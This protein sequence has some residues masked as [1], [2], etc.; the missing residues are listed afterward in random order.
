MGNVFH[1]KQFDV[2]HDRSA[3]KIGTDGVLLGAWTD[4]G[5][6]ATIWDA[7]CG[8]GL[9]ALMIAQRSTAKIYG[10]EIEEDAALEAQDNAL[11]SPWT[12]RIKVIHGDINLVAPDLPTP[13]LIICNP[14]FFKN[15]LKN[16]DAARSAARHESTLGA[17]SIIEI[18]AKFLSDIGCLSLIL[19]FDCY[20]EVEWNSA[21]FKLNIA[22][23]LD[24]RMSPS[25]TPSRTLWELSRRSV[26]GFRH[27]TADIRNIDGSYSDWYQ[28]LTLEYYTHLK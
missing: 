6:A 11:A 16:P 25:K 17:K 14:P 23:R 24:I 27:D 15:A 10:V 22:R 28:Q 19:P 7:G 5:E 13:D 12:N 9:L 2:V 1:F 20:E 4:P 26:F 21:L 18:A 3:M 8:S